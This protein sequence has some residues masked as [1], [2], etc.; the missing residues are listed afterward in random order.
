MKA[1]SAQQY[2]RYGDVPTQA[3]EEPSPL[4]SGWTIFSGVMMLLAGLFGAING[5]IALLNS[6]VYVTTENRI[7]LFDFTQWGWIHLIL[8]SF[9][10]IM[11]LIV[12]MTGALPARIIGVAVAILHAITQVA[13][14]EAYPFWTITTIALDV[15]V[16][17]GLLVP[18]P[19]NRR[20]AA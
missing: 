9:V 18:V 15:T 11:G 13:F 4:I 20:T 12:M 10:A 7:V 6:E 2:R 14:I 16:V 3:A 19:L 8:G 17:Y 1:Q 5:I